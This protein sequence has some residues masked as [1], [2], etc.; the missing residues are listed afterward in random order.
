VRV[1]LD[2]G[3]GGGEGIAQIIACGYAFD[4]Y[5]AFE[6]QPVYHAA[7]RAITDP[8]V[9]ACPYGLWHQTVTAPLHVGRRAVGASV[10]ADKLVVGKRHA[11]P[12]C[13]F[14]SAAEW[15]RRYLT[16]DDHVIAKV[17]CEG[18][19]CDILEDL[20]DSGEIAK[21][22]GLMLA[23]DVRKVPSQR[24]RE[25]QIRPR[26]AVVPHLWVLSESETY[27]RA[28]RIGSDGYL[29]QIMAAMGEGEG[30]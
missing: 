1:Y 11:I 25:A 7:L 24:A 28:K 6:P 22:H 14:V 20:L 21:L 15:F 5:Y 8:R 16:V 12:D 23:F 4:R 26:L 30:A 2:I 10:Y 3:A 17:N 19:E 18:A 27:R 13:Q 9:V 29:R